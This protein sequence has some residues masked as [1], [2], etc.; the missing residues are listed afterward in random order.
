M[1]TSKRLD[2]MPK[3][4]SPGQTTVKIPRYMIQAVDDFLKTDKAK[5]LGLDSK[6]DVVTAAVR[7]L[8]EKYGIT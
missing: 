5:R 2:R 1:D 4:K 6:S 3:T 8:L 7:D